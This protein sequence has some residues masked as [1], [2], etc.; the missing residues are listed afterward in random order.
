LRPC[1]MC[2]HTLSERPRICAY[3]RRLRLFE[4]LFF[5]YSQIC[6]VVNDVS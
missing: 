6:I 3:R 5:K 2:V 1:R 4:C